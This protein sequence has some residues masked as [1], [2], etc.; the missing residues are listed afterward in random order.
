MPLRAAPLSLVRDSSH[1][2]VQLKGTAPRPFEHN[3]FYH[4]ARRQHTTP[5]PRAKFRVPGTEA[6]TT[7]MTSLCGFPTPDS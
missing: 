5:L 7:S 6:I 3:P 2:E 1:G 4:H